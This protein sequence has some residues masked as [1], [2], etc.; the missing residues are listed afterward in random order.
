MSDLQERAGLHVDTALAQFIEHDVLPGLNMSPAPFWTGLADIFSR[1]SAEN[2]TLLVERDRMQAAID[3]WHRA[4]R[5]RAIA[6]PDYAEML[7]SIGYLAPGPAQEIPREAWVQIGL[8]ERV[9]PCKV[10]APGQQARQP[11]GR[12]QPLQRG[13]ERQILVQ[14]QHVMSKQRATVFERRR[15][16]AG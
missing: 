4:K 16:P 2:R 6:W 12:V 8:V 5:G 9:A 11:P 15:E 13:G 10:V 7:R 14:A 1:F 3:A